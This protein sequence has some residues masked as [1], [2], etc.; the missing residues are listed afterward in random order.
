[1]TRAR[2]SVEPNSDKACF[3]HMCANF[4]EKKNIKVESWTKILDNIPR[5]SPYGLDHTQIY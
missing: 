2:V 5:Y 1:M 4:Q 3:L